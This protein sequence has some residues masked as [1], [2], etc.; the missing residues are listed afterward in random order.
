MIRWIQF[1]DENTKFFQA[2]ATERYRKN[3]LASLKTTDGYTVD[4]HAGK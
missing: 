4:D 3:C 1:G 2:A